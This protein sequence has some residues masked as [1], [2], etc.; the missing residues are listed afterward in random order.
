MTNAR[1]LPVVLA[2][3][4][5]ACLAACS[6]S[7]PVADWRLDAQGASERATGAY[8]VGQT[9][10]ANSEWARA[11]QA[12]ARSAQPNAV[13]RVR[14]AQCAAQVASLVLEPC[15]GLATLQVD[16]SAALQAYERYLS[17]QWLPTD[18]AL[19]PATQQPLARA[20]SSGAAPGGAGIDARPGPH[21]TD[22]AALQAMADPL[23]RLVGAAVLLRAGQASP[24][25]VALAVSTASEQGWVRPLLA[26]LGVQAQ[27]AEQTGD[28]DTAQRA[29][30]RMDLL[31]PATPR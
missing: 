24:P 25:S 30:R 8:L 28:T 6:S 11:A 3:C 13:A 26:W 14:L 20:I 22:L 23:S 9:G 12:A 2:T 27:L 21:G 1:L 7:P 10:V 18:L 4:L 29:R 5:A 16:T 19:L 31:A 17:A 15:T